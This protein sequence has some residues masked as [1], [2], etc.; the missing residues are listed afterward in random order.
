MATAGGID[1]PGPRSV[2]ICDG[3]QRFNVETIPPENGD[4]KYSPQKRV[5]IFKRNL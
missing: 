1:M 2:L 4:E 5:W 3:A